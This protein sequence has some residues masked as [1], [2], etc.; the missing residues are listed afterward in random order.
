MAMERKTIII[1][2]PMLLL[3]LLLLFFTRSVPTQNVL[4]WAQQ[5]PNLRKTSCIDDNDCDND[6]VDNDIYDNDDD[7]ENDDKQTVQVLIFSQSLVTSCD[8]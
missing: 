1:A 3:P 8:R 5:E 7:L 2:E 4:G 6:G